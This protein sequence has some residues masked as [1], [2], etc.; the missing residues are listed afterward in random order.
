MPTVTLYRATD[1]IDSYGS[2][3]CFAADEDVAE[4]YLDN[5]GFGGS[6]LLSIEVPVDPDR[7]LSLVDGRRNGVPYGHQARSAWSNLAEALGLDADDEDVVH[8]LREEGA[9]YIH[10]IID[11]PRR[12]DELHEAGYDWVVYEDSFPESAVTWAYLGEDIDL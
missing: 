7:V 3:A 4:E 2:G 5:P 12:R 6:T 11:S 10:G 8:A 1:R 9:H